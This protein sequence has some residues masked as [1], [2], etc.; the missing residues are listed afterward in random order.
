MFNL[1]S[2]AAKFTPDG[3]A[4]TV[5]CRKDRKKC[6]MS[7]SDTG[8]GIAPREREKIFEDFYQTGAS[9]KDKTPGTGLGLPITKRIVEMH[10]GR[11][12][13]ESKG[14]GKGSRF[15]FALPV[16]TAHRIKLKEATSVG[17]A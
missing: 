4:I 15:S 8:I 3:G 16:V 2:N 7:V 6:I 5:E 10:G 13:V 17:G 9:T 14:L 1:L 12:W 11:I